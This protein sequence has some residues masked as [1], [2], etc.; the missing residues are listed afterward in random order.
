MYFNGAYA[1]YVVNYVEV[2]DYENEIL[3]VPRDRVVCTAPKYICFIVYVK[4]QNQ[5]RSCVPGFLKSFSSRKGVS[6]T[7]TIWVE[8]WLRS[9][10]KSTVNSKYFPKSTVKQLH[11][12]DA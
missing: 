7:Y 8:L 4:L 5:A 10:W 1:Y 9:N 3:S 2:N 12:F 6:G 11:F